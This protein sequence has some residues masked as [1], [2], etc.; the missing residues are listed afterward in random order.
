MSSNVFRDLLGGRK[1]NLPE[2]VLNLPKKMKTKTSIFSAL[3]EG[4]ASDLATGLTKSLCQ[5]VSPKLV[6]KD[7]SDHNAEVTR[8]TL[9]SVRANLQ[10]SLDS[11]SAFSLL[12]HTFGPQA[13]DGV[14]A[15]ISDSL[16]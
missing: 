8:T 7:I 6:R 11:R 10:S 2:L 14:L 13:V 16:K 5:N 15:F 9:A 12:T 3:T 1:T 4:E